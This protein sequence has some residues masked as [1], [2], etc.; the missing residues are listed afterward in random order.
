ML[1]DKIALVTGATSGIGKAIAIGLAQQGATVV[2]VG[3]DRRKGEAVKAEIAALTGN[4]ALDLLLADLSSQQAIRHLAQEFQQRHA[5]LQILVNNAGAQLRQRQLSVDGIE[6]NLAINH[7]ASFLLTN[8]LLDTLRSSA[9]ARII[10]VASNSMT[11]SINLHDLQSE[12]AFKPFRAYGQAKLAM[13]LCTYALARRLAETNVTVN[14]LHPGVTATNIVDDAAPRILR[15]FTGIIKRFL[16]TPEQAAQTAVYLASS[17]ELDGVTGQYFVRGKPK[18]SVPISYNH[19]LQDRV[20]A[21]SAALVNLDA[22][23]PSE[24]ALRAAGN[25]EGGRHHERP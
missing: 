19:A 23:S 9:P 5:Q 15:P 17:P 22:S 16:L 20:W 10:N 3:R 12:Q 13:V 24:L 18:P 4:T 21:E 11:R 25:S 7:L 2:L 1:H 14:A 8:L 6:M